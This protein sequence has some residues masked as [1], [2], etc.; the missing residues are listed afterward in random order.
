MPRLL[1]LLDVI[2]ERQQALDNDHDF[3]TQRPH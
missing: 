3:R 2:L 1:F